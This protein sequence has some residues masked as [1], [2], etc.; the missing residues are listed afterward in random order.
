MRV[1][2]GTARGCA[3]ATL[4]GDAT[5]PTAERV[6]EAVFSALHYEIAGRAAL[7]LF[8]GSGQMGIE[9]LSR[10]ASRCT[11][12]ESSRR[13]CAVIAENL[14]RTKLEARAEVVCADAVSFCGAGEAEYD[15]MFL[16]PPY[17]MGAIP[18]LM[19]RAALLLRPGGIAVCETSAQDELPERFPPLALDRSRRYGR[20]LIW[21][22]RGRVG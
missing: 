1:I 15:L 5:R 9:A 14:R 11:F 13:A 10:G 6:K 4:P 20:T 12:V 7:D 3:L 8:A 2:T 19:P 18:A 22:Y 16:D 17:R 21:I